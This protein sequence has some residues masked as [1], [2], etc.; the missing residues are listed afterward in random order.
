MKKNKPGSD[1]PKPSNPV[2]GLS[3]P[4]LRSAVKWFSILVIIPILLG[5]IALSLFVNSSLVHSYLNSSFEREAGKSLGVP[6]VL[7]NF[8]VHLSSL[9]VD[10]YG[11][12][13][14]GAKPHPN[15]PLLQVQHLQAGI[16]IVSVLRR[17]WYLDSLR[18]DRPVIQ[19]YVD[20]HGVSNIPAFK[21]TGG[22]NNN[23]IFDLGIRRA[24]I[25]GGMVYYN[26]Q[27]SSLAA[28]LHDVNLG[29]TF[30]EPLQKYSGTLS[31][32]TGAHHLRLS[33]PTAAQHKRPL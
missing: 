15:P 25:D 12:T 24:V 9:S 14:S 26:D 22:G 29:A 7:Q 8:K 30:N 6:V 4:R 28:D 32:L 19:V 21:S 16:K 10:L 20:P 17:N 5:V 27:P 31:L 3:S 13:V 2:R 33:E 18:I 11:L 1:A 23:A